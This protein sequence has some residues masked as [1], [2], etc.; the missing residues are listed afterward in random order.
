VAFVLPVNVGLY[1]QAVTPPA[2]A[3][4]RSLVFSSNA[5]RGTIL[6]RTGKRCQMGRTRI[7]ASSMVSMKYA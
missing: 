1:R 6:C 3:A 4:V 5:N 2:Q 7:F